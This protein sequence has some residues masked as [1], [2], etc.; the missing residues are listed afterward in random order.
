MKSQTTDLIT[1]L[2]RQLRELTHDHEDSTTTPVFEQVYEHPQASF[3][4]K[5]SFAVLEINDMQFIR[6]A[7]YVL[8][9]EDAAQAEK[10]IYAL[11]DILCSDPHFEGLKG[12]RIMYLH[13][14]GKFYRTLTYFY[15]L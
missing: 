3:P 7:L 1:E 9:E 8:I 4:D 13:L 14:N 5:K 12:G 15:P 2:A 6:I 10:Q 11:R